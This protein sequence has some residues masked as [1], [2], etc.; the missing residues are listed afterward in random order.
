MIFSKYV[1]LPWGN[2]LLVVNVYDTCQLGIYCLSV[3]HMNTHPIHPY[4]SLHPP[5][6]THPVI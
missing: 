6:L 5:T 3:M 1:K 4:T 2:S